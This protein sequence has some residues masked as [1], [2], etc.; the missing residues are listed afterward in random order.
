MNHLS[1]SFEFLLS[2]AQVT[3]FTQL[4]AV[5]TGASQGSV[6]DCVQKVSFEF[7]ST[8]N[9]HITQD[10]F[11]C[12]LIRFIIIVHL[13]LDGTFDPASTIVPNLSGLLG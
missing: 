10:R 13:L 9:E 7:L 3:S 12:S 6:M 8:P 4:S 2:D 5:L 1:S 11:S